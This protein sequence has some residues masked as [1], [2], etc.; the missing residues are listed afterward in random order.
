MGLERRSA[1]TMAVESVFLALDWL[2]RGRVRTALRF[3]RES[4]ALLRDNDSVGMLAC[5]LA[6]VAQAAAQA[7][8]AD[9]ADAAAREMEDARLGHLRFATEV[10]LGR[11]WAAAAAGELSRARD[12]A[13]A[14]VERAGADGLDGFAVR[15]WHELCRLGDPRAAAAPLAALSERVDG[16]FAGLAAA[17]A[18]ALAAGDGRALLDVA[19]RFAATDALLVAAEEASA[20][21][22][23]LRDAGRHGS[24]AAAARRSAAL[25]E[26]CE[27]A[28]PPT[29]LGGVAAEELTPRE[30]E[31]ALLAASGLSS[32][33][34]AQ[35]LVV[36]VRT[37]DN[38]LSRTY[39]KLG[40]AGRDELPSALA[41]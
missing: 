3:A 14:A 10:G 37:V 21:A 9:V 27:G 32:R 33:E 19:E 5:A 28:R 34:I 18:A 6:A 26:R 38:H 4:V 8:E 13:R 16:E 41:G 20:A 30:R 15:A 11:A 7:G 25:L 31:I 12:E 17:H 1:Q 36:S 23:A 40:V 29:L 35:R 22:G 24:A 2:A 39:R